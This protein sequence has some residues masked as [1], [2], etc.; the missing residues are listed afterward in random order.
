MG[1]RR[2]AIRRRKEVNLLIKM[3]EFEYEISG[4]ANVNRI[5]PQNGSWYY[6]YLTNGNIVIHGQ[7]SDAAFF[8]PK[9]FEQKVIT[10]G[11][12]IV[13]NNKLLNKK[14]IK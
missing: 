10:N 5:L 11:G 9:K 6:H 3:N 8:C 4:I 7:P 2:L 12:Y 14:K 1:M 13:N